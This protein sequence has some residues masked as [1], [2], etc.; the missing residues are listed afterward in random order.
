MSSTSQ[1]TLTFPATTTSELVTGLKPGNEYS[2][3]VAAVNSRGAG[4][5]SV[6]AVTSL[7]RA[8]TATSLK[9]SSAKLTYGHEQAELFTVTVTPRYAT[10][11]PTGTVEIRKS[12][13]TLCTVKLSSGKGSCSLAKDVLHAGSYHLYAV[14][15]RN[16]NFIGSTSP[17]ADLLVA[18]AST[19]TSLVLSENTLTYGHEQHERI[20][21]TV[22]AQYSG[23]KVTGTV[24]VN[25]LSCVI[26]L[27]SGRG[28]CT[29]S[30]KSFRVGRHS[31]EATYWGSTSL[32]ASFSAKKNLTVLK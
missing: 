17:T 3:A 32:V 25:G 2:F 12:T 26:R 14:Y 6:S 30:A 4:A 28:S 18:K 13:T 16:T 7:Q 22:T 23:L 9:L 10:A 5:P 8:P 19:R 11:T 1:G 29:S 31:L 15:A 27:S 24:T 20:S 21:V